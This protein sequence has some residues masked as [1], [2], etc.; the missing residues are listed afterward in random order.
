MLAA[1]DG[2]AATV[3]AGGAAASCDT[4]AYTEIGGPISLTDSTGKRVT[5]DTFR[6][7]ASLVYFG[8]TYCPD[9]CPATLVTIERALR[10]LPND[11]QPPRTILISL[12]PERDTPASMASYIATDVFPDDMVGLTG[13][14]DE[15][16]AAADAFKI[17][18]ER[19]EVTENTAEYTIDHSSILYLMDEN[20]SLKTFFTYEA[21]PQSISDC[22]ALQL[23]K[24]H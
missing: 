17:A 19:I 11:I 13:T 21:D 23:P 18:Y 16:R 2:K 12:D 10:R 15:I 5:E 3:Q 1:C 7:R 4:R 14:P 9:V 20:W 8:F 24:R 22:L 6:G